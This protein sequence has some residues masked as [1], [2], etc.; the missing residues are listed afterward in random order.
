MAALMFGVDDVANAV[1]GVASKVID[2]VW[3]D[4]AAQAQAK[5]QLLQLAQDGTLKQ[6]MA[7]TDL[8][9]AQDAINQVE[10]SN[11]SI[12][13]AG[14]RPF[15]GWVCGCAL[16]FNYVAAPLGNWIAA[17][18][19]SHAA[20]PMLDFSVMSPILTGMLGL[21]AMRTYEKVQ[22]INAGQ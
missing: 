5:F 9:K 3:P 19:G 10:A 22:G 4:P 17:L 8:A 20:I 11:T 15:V 16:G 2:R 13:V 14:W 18:A 12:F 7:D 6:L 21:G 1:L